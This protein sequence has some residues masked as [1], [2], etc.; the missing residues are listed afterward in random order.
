MRRIGRNKT[1]Y[2]KYCVM[3]KPLLFTSIPP[4]IRRK[5]VIFA[6][7]KR[8][9]VRE[10]TF[11]SVFYVLQVSEYLLAVRLPTRQS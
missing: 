11:K 8:K 4:H 3:V 10:G 1:Q 9:R 7:I 6:E 2:K 5:D